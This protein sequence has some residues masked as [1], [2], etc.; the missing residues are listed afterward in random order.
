MCGQQQLMLSTQ[1]NA[2]TIRNAIRLHHQDAN[3]PC[4]QH[5]MI[6]LRT[7]ISKFKPNS[8]VFCD[9]LVFLFFVLLHMC[10]YFL[11][12]FTQYSG[13]PESEGA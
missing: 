13:T 1:L 2:K 4:S 9:I 7:S 3:R 6:V 11:H 12:N 10:L 8:S 5:T